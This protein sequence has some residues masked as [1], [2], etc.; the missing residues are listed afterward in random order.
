MTCPPINPPIHKSTNPIPFDPI[1]FASLRLCGFAFNPGPSQRKDP[2]A[3]GRKNCRN[4]QG[5]VRRRTPA[6]SG[7]GPSA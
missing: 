5:T 4:C 7:A 2:K 6:L 3:P 1:R